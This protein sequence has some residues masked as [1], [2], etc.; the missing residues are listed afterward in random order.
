MLE[1]LTFYLQPLIFAK[2]I[3]HLNARSKQRISLHCMKNLPLMLCLAMVA[4]LTALS[5]Q[6]EALPNSLLWRIS[7]NGLKKPSYLYG[8]LNLSQNMLDSQA[9]SIDYFKPYEDRLLKLADV[10]D[11]QQKTGLEK[12]SY[13]VPL[14]IVEILGALNTPKTNSRLDQWLASADI[15]VRMDAMEALI[16]NGKSIPA[17]ALK[18]LAADKHARVP[19][20]NMLKSRHKLDLF[21]KQ[22]LTQRAFGESGIYTFLM[23]E[24]YSLVD[25]VFYLTQK[26]VLFKAKKARF[27][28]YQVSEQVGNKRIP[29]LGCAGPFDL[30]PA[31]V[32][33]DSIFAQCDLEMDYDPKQFEKQSLGLIRKIEELVKVF[34]ENHD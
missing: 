14:T 6:T 2:T 34:Q 15:S 22:Y 24:D 1:R 10:F 20:Y 26:E 32:D 4:S 33:P 17:A 27:L 21:P 13:V 11:A 5:A 29:H 12:W 31:K 28:F 23:E 3:N 9:I 19:L 8:I 18:G 16:R 7:G 30:D 25:T